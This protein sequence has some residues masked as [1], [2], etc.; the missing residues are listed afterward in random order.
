MPLDADQIEKP[1]RKLRKFIKG[2]G[3]PPAAED[4]H[5]LR[6]NCRRLESSLDVLSLDSSGSG[7]GISKQIGRL[8]KH[9]GKIRDIDVLTDYLVGMKHPDSERDCHVRLLEHLGGSRKKYVKKLEAVRKQYRAQLRRG[10]KN[11]SKKLEKVASKNQN[12]RSAKHAVSAQ[13]AATALTRMSELKDPPRLL[14]SNLHPYRLKVKE[15]RNVLQMAGEAE[16]QQFVDKLGDVKD[17]I[18]EWHDWEVL[19]DLARDVLNHGKGCRLVIEMRRIADT[20]YK[21]ALSLTNSMRREFLHVPAGRTRSSKPG[22]V[23]L[24]QPALSAAAALA[25]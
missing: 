8:R 13:L 18:G 14:R 4:I 10:L 7:R 11:I 23:K 1:I 16:Q 3:A 6:T 5:K 21:E 15:L 24:A 12:D 19:V 2:I 25:A 17:A 22:T 20:K 9:A